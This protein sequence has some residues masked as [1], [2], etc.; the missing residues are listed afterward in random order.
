MKV[1]LS[2]VL[3]LAMAALLGTLAPVS[4]EQAPPTK[5][6]PQ[7]KG[8][9]ASGK[10]DSQHSPPVQPKKAEKQQAPKETQKQ[11][12]DNDKKPKDRRQ[13]HPPNVQSN[14]RAQQSVHALSPATT[15]GPVFRPA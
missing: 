13:Q 12:K 8:K 11:L 4:G 5:E 3:G 10:H 7:S 9:D 2:V 1:M 15:G 14:T 6:Q